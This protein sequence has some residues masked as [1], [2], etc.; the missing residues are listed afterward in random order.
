MVVAL[1]VCISGLAF[2]T[3]GYRVVPVQASWFYTTVPGTTMADENSGSMDIPAEKQGQENR[4]D[5]L[6]DD[7]CAGPTALL[8]VLDRPT[9]SDSVCS[10]KKNQ[11]IAELGYVY[12]IET[13]NN[14]GTLQTLPQPEIRYG[15]GGNIELK[16]FPPNYVLQTT[17]T[18]GTT[19]RIDGA[20][21]A[22]IGVKYEFG[23]G[24]KWGFAV[25]SAVTFASGRKDFSA[26]ATGAILNGI[27]AYN[28]N[29]DI[30]VSLQ[31][32]LF[33]LFSQVDSAQE[34]SINPILVVTDQLNEI[35]DKV[36]LYA[37]CYNSI[38]LLHG[39]GIM[40]S[41]DAGVQ[42]LLYQNIEIDLEAG[43]NLTDLSSNNIMYVG[44]GTGLEF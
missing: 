39:T 28:V 4:Q 20:S 43:H 26:N 19:R 17:R 44:F 11:V 23:Y 34:T 33:H 16:L 22:G 25:D 41:I 35:T 9:M 3:A 13:G 38:D 21:D 31:I 37:E 5:V 27:F 18:A 14:A 7:S 10:A 36:Q 30:G 24:E 2:L 1:L 42:Y 29:E 12:Q 40:S 32:G 15:T 6:P 8:S